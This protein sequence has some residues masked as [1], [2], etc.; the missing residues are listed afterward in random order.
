MFRRPPHR[1][2]TNRRPQ[3]DQSLC[4]GRSR[5]RRAKADGDAVRN[6]RAFISYSHD[7]AALLTLLHKHLATLRREQ[8]LSTWTDREILAGGLIDAHVAEELENAQ[9]YLL[10]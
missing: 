3:P 7:D 5:I 6:I 8:M 9:L 1:R 10:L 2:R 4:H